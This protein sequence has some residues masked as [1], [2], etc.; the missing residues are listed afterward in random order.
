MSDSLF[1]SKYFADLIL[2]VPLARLYTYKV[3]KELEGQIAIGSRVIVPFGKQKVI[4]GIIAS[5]H[6]TPPKEAEAKYILDSLD[7]APLITELQLKIFNWVSRYYLCHVGEVLKAALPSGLKLSS[8]SIVQLNKLIELNPEELNEK[9]RFVIDALKQKETLSFQEIEKLLNQKSVH[10]LINKLAQKNIVYILDQIK[11][12]YKPKRIKKVRLSNLV[13]TA[14]QV[15]E[16]ISELQKKKKQLEVVHSYLTLTPISENNEGVN[17]TSLIETGISPSSLKTLINNDIFEEFEIVISRFNESPLV[18][19]KPK[20]LALPQQNA[21]DT[22]FKNFDSKPVQLLHGVTGSGKTEIYIHLI[23]AIIDNGQQVL[24]LLP[25]IALTTQIVSRLRKVFGEK[26]GIY[27]SK[28]S[29]NER[30]ETFKDVA[31]GKLQL[32]V[33]VRSSVFLPFRD[34]GLIIVDEEHDASYK[35]YE[36]APRYNARDT[37]VMLGVIHHAKVVL[38]TATPSV[39]SYYNSKYGKCTF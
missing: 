5:I 10:R 26:M 14:E 12:K 25:E 33:G 4:T 31:N 20:P 19:E 22:I 18:V 8:E 11:E 38:G 13:S 36:P 2:P 15:E 17:K 30:V 35:Q 7:D 39:E 29:D 28:F 6:E 37:A 9:E 16:L 23:Q 3:P 34:L 1:E 32:I 21:L 27:H 24:Y